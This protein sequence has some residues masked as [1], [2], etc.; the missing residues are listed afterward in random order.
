MTRAITCLRNSGRDDG[1]D[2]G[3]VRD[4]LHTL[5]TTPLIS[6]EAYYAVPR[7]TARC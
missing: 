5:T 7:R 3:T 2:S 6:N 1:N 4:R